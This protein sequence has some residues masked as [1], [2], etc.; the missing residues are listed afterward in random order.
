M[1]SPRQSLSEAERTVWLVIGVLFTLILVTG[2]LFW[3]KV[4]VY[5]P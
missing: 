5:G 4:S 1:K 2:Y 3:K